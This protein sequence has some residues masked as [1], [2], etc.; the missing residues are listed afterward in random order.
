MFLRVLNEK[1]KNRRQS[2]SH[3]SDKSNKVQY[4]EWALFYNATMVFAKSTINKLYA[5]SFHQGFFLFLYNL[6]STT[7]NFSPGIYW[8]VFIFDSACQIQLPNTTENAPRSCR[9]II[10]RK[11]YMLCKE[12]FLLALPDKLSDI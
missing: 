5:D 7:N 12:Q 9:T 3:T 2:I 10:V 6:C 1:N 4:K 11:I 8:Q